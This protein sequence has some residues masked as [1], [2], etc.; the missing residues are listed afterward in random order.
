MWVKGGANPVSRQSRHLLPLGGALHP[1]GAL[2]PRPEHCQLP[3][4]NRTAAV[5]FHGVLNRLQQHLDHRGRRCGHQKEVPRRWAAGGQWPKR[6]LGEARG[7]QAR[8]GDCGGPRCSCTGIH[9][10][11]YPPKA[12]SLVKWWAHMHHYMS[13]PQGALPY[14]LPPG[15]G[16]SS[17]P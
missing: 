8:G 6:R 12:Q 4:G 14:Q 16:T 17:V 1:W 15:D 3:S 13:I 2:H 5:A 9:G 7:N 10:L 11:P